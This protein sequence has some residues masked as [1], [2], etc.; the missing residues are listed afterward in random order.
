MSREA[1]NTT[2]LR[3][4]YARVAPDGQQNANAPIN[5]GCIP[6]SRMAASVNPT[7][8]DTVAIGSTTFKFVASLGAAGAQVQVLR[9]GSA[10][11]SY[12]NL[13]LAINGDAASKNINWVEATTPFAG[14]ILA[15][16]V[17]ATQLRIRQ[18]TARGGKAQAGVSGS[19]A[20][21]AS[22]TGGASFWSVA[23]LNQSG[24]SPQDCDQAYGQITITA[25]MITNGFVD[26]ELP[27]Q[28]TLQ[29]VYV[30]DTTGLQRFITDTVTIPANQQCLHLNLPGG[31]A[32]HVQANDIIVWWV[33]V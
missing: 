23:N 10:A 19:I 8:N 15:D 22:I 4:N 9:G 25:A 29:D 30:I 32:P 24:K 31:A 14:A 26:I 17:Q 20:L 12:A 18:A 5:Q 16:M 13:V 7:A 2:A 6:G 33:A 1:S 27:I 28:P 21:T 3:A 11:V